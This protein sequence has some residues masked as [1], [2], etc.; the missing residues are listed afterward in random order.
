MGERF[1]DTAQRANHKQA[2][3]LST[4]CASKIIGQHDYKTA[5]AIVIDEAFSS[6]TCPLA[7]R[8]SRHHRIYRRPHCGTARPRDSVG[9]TNIL[10]LGVHVETLAGRTLPE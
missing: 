9:A 5:G 2:Q 6:Q 8:W 10:A 4:A 3:Q 7:G 1:T